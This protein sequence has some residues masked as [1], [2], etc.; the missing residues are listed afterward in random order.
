MISTG[1]LPRV[2]QPVV[3]EIPSAPESVTRSS[4]SRVLTVSRQVAPRLLATLNHHDSGDTKVH[5]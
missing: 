5:S 3:G 1:W 2:R 4:T